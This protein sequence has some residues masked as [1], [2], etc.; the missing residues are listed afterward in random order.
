MSD[1]L[2]FMN[3][4]FVRIASISFF[5]IFSVLGCNQGNYVTVKHVKPVNRNRYYN[6]SK[7]KRKKRV[8]YTKKKILKR[9]PKT[10]TAPVKNRKKTKPPQ[11]KDTIQYESDT[12]GFL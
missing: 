10:A 6:P 5:L 11:K 7:D 12:T 3:K 1:Y 2:A 8:K 9:S 4:S